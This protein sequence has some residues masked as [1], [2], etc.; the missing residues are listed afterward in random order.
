MR[1]CE[2]LQ[3]KHM[4]IH[5][6][7]QKTTVDEAEPADT[8]T[9]AAV[10][11]AAYI[12]RG[13]GISTSTQQPPLRTRP[14]VGLAGLVVAVVHRAGRAGQGRGGDRDEAAVGHEISAAVVLRPLR[15]CSHSSLKHRLPELHVS[16][17]LVILSSFGPSWV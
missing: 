10:G 9:A 15:T 3:P 17:L 4:N 7:A 12:G 1:A 5:S 16:T 13:R 8:R 2:L 6:V 11:S 14:L